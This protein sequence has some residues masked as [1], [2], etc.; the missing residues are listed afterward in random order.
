MNIDE[1]TS[2]I[3]CECKS[4]EHQIIIHKD[5]DFENNHKLI[6]LSPHLYTYKNF[7]KRVI[8]AFKYIFGYK[9]KYGAWDSII[10]SKE[11]YQPLKDAV[12]FLES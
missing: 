10:V 6:Y 2:I 3:I 8:V 4:S 5:D 1:T 12:E 11:N 9:S 7:F